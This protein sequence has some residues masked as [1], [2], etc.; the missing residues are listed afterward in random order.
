MGILD[1]FGGGSDKPAVDPSMAAMR[2]LGMPQ[3][4]ID[5]YA[6]EQ[7][8]NRRMQAM[9]MII[10]GLGNAVSGYQG[11]APVAAPS[12]GS[13]GGGSAGGSLDS[14][15]GI[16]DRA[17]KFSK[18]QEGV[19]AQQQM[20]S[21]RQSIMADPRLTEIEK[22]SY[23]T[24]PEAYLKLIESDVTRR[25]APSEVEVL[26]DSDK[27]PIGAWDKKAQRMLTT[28]EMAQK[29]II[30]ASGLSQT[31]AWDMEDSLRKEYGAAPET[32]RYI[33]ADPVYRSMVGNAAVDT[34]AA[35]LDLVYGI[36][37]ILDPNS[38]VREGEMV[39]V[40]K[41]SPFAEMLQGYINS[42]SGQGKLT[43][44]TRARLLEMARGR[45]GELRGAH[46]EIARGVKTRA[47]ERNID[48]ARVVTRNYEPLPDAPI[49]SQ[50][51][52]GFIPT[53]FI[54][55][56]RSIDIRENPEAIDEFNRR[57]GPRMAQRVLG[58]R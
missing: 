23:V 48:E 22:K 15:D 52:G 46:D 16:V 57:F 34:G 43:P 28:E 12:I 32:K 14:M 50:Q 26:F 54:G 58:I 42:I 25:M 18:L 40:N 9:Q 24:N 39:M 31:K 44:E 3:S 2:D 29:N 5:A 20:A 38:V 49:Y 33:E 36:G 1:F 21:I 7:E 35:D 27:R 4:M 6:A 30:P 51:I 13:S 8:R 19:R 53:E 56:L 37:K 41:T 45:M 10:G 11:M 55:R 17:L 47:K